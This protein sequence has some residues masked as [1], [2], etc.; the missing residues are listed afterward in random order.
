[1]PLRAVPCAARPG[2]GAGRAARPFRMNLIHVIKIF[3]LTKIGFR[4]QLD[5]SSLC[6]GHERPAINLVFFRLKRKYEYLRDSGEKVISFLQRGECSSS[7]AQNRSWRDAGEVIPMMPCVGAPPHAGQAPPS[8]LVLSRH[9][10]AEG[11]CRLGQ[12]SAVPSD[13]LA[14]RGVQPRQGSGRTARQQREVE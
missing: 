9:R 1:M 10:Q 4:I 5:G 8:S 6:R 13:S 11:R 7:T 2:G 12:A 14:T 3:D